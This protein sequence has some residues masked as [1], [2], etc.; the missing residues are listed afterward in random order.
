[1]FVTQTRIGVLMV[2]LSSIMMELKH[3]DSV[4]GNSLMV[5][6]SYNNKPINHLYI[7]L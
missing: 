5:R 6:L 2:K 4:Y 1:M 3:L 7:D